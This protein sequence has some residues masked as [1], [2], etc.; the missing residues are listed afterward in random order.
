MNFLFQFARPQLVVLLGFSL[1]G[2]SL[3]SVSRA[4]S[5]LEQLRQNI[6]NGYY[7][8][9][10]Q[11]SGPAAIEENPNNPE[12]F[13]LYGYALYYSDN[14]SAAR[15][16][17]EKAKTLVGEA[18][19]PAYKHLDGLLA[20][21]EGNLTEATALLET[22]FLEGQ[23][24]KMAMDWGI[25]AW[26]AGDFDTALRAFEAASHTEEGQKEIGPHLNRGRILQQARTDTN[27]AI[28]AY[29]TALNVFEANDL[30]GNVPPGVV[31]ANF[32]LG[33]IYENL[34]DNPLAKS[35]YEA[36]LGYDN[37]YTPAKDALSRLA[38]NP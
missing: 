6:A 19:T 31:E 17:L 28:E 24:Y 4:Q 20:A 33:E 2:F 16:Q 26:Q 10:A 25:T 27:E 30:G 13:L 37:N 36:T 8:S 38:R 1:L 14:A 23:D 29:K 9:A 32:R 11:I 35:Y 5:S 3:T 21:N 18:S 22:A 12:A 7:A 15:E 34:G